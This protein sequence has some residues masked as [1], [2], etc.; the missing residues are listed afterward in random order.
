[1][2]TIHDIDAQILIKEIAEKLKGKVE[3]PDYI[4]FVKTGA[5]RERPP[6]SKDFWYIRCA[7]LLRYIYLNGPIGISRLRNKYG[8]RKRHIAY[9]H[10]HHYKAGGSIIKDALDQLEKLGY[11]TKVK[12]GRIITPQGRSFVDHIINDMVAKNG[13]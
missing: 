2:P 11:I 7:S 8:N 1:M 6:A 12:K 5:G 3:R 9:I 4:D 10:H 13:K